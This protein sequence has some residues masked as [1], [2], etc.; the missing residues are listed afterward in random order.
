MSAFNGISGEWAHDFDDFDAMLDTDPNHQ[1]RPAERSTKVKLK[2]VRPM[3]FKMPRLDKLV[4]L[5]SLALMYHGI[6]YAIYNTENVSMIEVASGLIP[7][8]F[9][10][11]RNNCFLLKNTFNWE[12]I[13]DP[14]G[15]LFLV[16]T[17]K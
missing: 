13:N 14:N 15:H 10:H 7:S 1:P 17:R 3:P 12:L 11:L 5:Q 8:E 2:I 6:Y 16:P 9:P 4:G